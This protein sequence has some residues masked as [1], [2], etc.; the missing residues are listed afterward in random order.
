MTETPPNPTQ[1]GVTRAQVRAAAH[2][3]FLW[4]NELPG[5]PRFVLHHVAGGI[6]IQE[7]QR[8]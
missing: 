5:D 1:L 3:L 8:P 4:N 7:G 2:A 6:T